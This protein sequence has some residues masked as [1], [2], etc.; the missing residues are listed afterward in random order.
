MVLQTP[1]PARLSQGQGPH[2]P[3]GAGP[4]GRLARAD[5]ASGG[6]RPLLS[7]QGEHS[8]LASAFGGG[9]TQKSPRASLQIGAGWAATD[10]PPA[11]PATQARGGSHSAGRQR[12]SDTP[13]KSSRRLGFL[14]FG[15]RIGRA[16]STQAW[17]GGEV[18]RVTGTHRTAPVTTAPV[19]HSIRGRDRMGPRATGRVPTP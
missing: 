8:W 5:G 13:G 15:K 10:W 18:C 3:C 9:R 1:P 19:T 2:S 14:P 11:G 12:L 16:P 17:C 4:D 6:T 7:P